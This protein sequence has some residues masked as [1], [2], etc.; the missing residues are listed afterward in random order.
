LRAERDAYAYLARALSD[1]ER[2][3]AVKPHARERE[4]EH[5]GKSS[6]WGTE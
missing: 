6:E 3:H 4:R 1:D 5:D 2:H